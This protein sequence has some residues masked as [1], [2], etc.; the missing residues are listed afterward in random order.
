MSVFSKAWVEALKTEIFR[1]LKQA[2]SPKG[3]GKIHPRV[4]KSDLFPNLKPG[5]GGSNLYG[6][7]GKK[8]AAVGGAG[9]SEGGE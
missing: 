7:K 2:P 1:S 8:D 9:G 5:E 4:R 6:N 3:S